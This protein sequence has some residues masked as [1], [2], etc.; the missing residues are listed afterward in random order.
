MTRLKLHIEDCDENY[1]RRRRRY[2]PY[3]YSDDYERSYDHI[4]PYDTFENIHLSKLK[5]LHCEGFAALIL[6]DNSKF[7]ASNLKSLHICKVD[8][9]SDIAI[10][11]LKRLMLVGVETLSLIDCQLHKNNM[12]N[13][14]STVR[15]NIAYRLLRADRVIENSKI[16]SL[17]LNIK[18][19]EET[20]KIC[21]TIKNIVSY[22]RYHKLGMDNFHHIG[23]AIHEISMC[24]QIIKVSNINYLSFGRIK[25]NNNPES[26]DTLLHAMET[27]QIE[28]LKKK[29]G[30]ENENV[31]MATVLA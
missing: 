8:L 16:K 4:K 19:S 30:K 24:S 1:Y 21:A 6:L 27:I 14:G 29:Q 25:I 31:Q 12:L 20:T 28:I 23:L 26:I 3:R 18:Q 2:Y 15:T 17:L 13:N 9:S 10:N 7:I 22:M 11:I 5:K